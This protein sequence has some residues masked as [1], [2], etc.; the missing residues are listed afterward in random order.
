MDQVQADFEAWFSTRHPTSDM[1]R[2][3]GDDSSYINSCVDWA[4]Q[5]FQ[6]GRMP[7]VRE[8]LCAHSEPLY[9]QQFGRLMRAE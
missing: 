1:R 2:A 8:S 5:G 4:W 7:A 6:G 3:P 9:V